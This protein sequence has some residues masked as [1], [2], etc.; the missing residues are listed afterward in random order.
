MK[1]SNR[2]GYKGDS[3]KNLQKIIDLGYSRSNIFS[4]WL[5]LMLSA[6]LSLSDNLKRGNIK[7]GGKLDG[8]YEERYLKVI[9]RYKNDG[10]QG[11]RPADYFA[12]AYHALLKEIEESNGD[13]LG[14]I[15]MQEISYGEHGQFFTPLHIAQ[16]MAEIVSA[17][18]KSEPGAQVIC[19]PCCGSG[20]MLLAAAKEQPE[21][22]LVGIDLDERCAKMCALN[23]SFRG[24][25]AD[26]YH[27]DSLAGKMETVW[28]VR[29]GGLMQEQKHP[30]TPERMKHYAAEHKG[31][32]AP[33]QMALI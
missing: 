13:P 33:E 22:R 9:Q 14:E 23:M 1:R 21:A 4:D 6:L 31:N 2:Q 12:A 10:G 3:W 20:V 19:D 11:T 30:E 25:S 24:L 15:Y 7:D 28:M 27:G 5:D 18:S 32:D 16:M 8:E 29:G 26:V 17:P